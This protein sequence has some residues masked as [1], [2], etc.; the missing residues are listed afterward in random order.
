MVKLGAYLA[1]FME[2]I[3]H[4]CVI[5]CVCDDSTVFMSLGRDYPLTDIDLFQDSLSLVSAGSQF[6]NS[7]VDERVPPS[8]LLCLGVDHL[9]LELMK[10]G[11]VAEG[12]VR[13]R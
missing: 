9:L 5:T 2:G 1:C 13:R 6:H 10:E 3:F 4:S 11:D 8:R 12:G 7:P